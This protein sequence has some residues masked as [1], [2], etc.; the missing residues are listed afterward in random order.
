MCKRVDFTSVPHCI[1]LAPRCRCRC[2]LNICPPYIQ[3]TFLPSLPFLAM[4]TSW[5]HALCTPSPYVNSAL[6]FCQGLESASGIFIRY[7]IHNTPDRFGS[8]VLHFLKLTLLSSLLC[9][10][11]IC[12]PYMQSAFLPFLAMHTSRKQLGALLLLM[13]ILLYAFVRG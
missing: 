3:P 9:S 7:L 12:L 2:S 8:P 5:K 11:N 13:L 10:L 4:H 6:H 1:S